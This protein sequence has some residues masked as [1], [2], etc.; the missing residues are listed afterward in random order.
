M[1][2]DLPFLGR[3][4]S[5]P[6]LGTHVT[7]V[8]VTQIWSE[9]RLPARSQRILVETLALW[10]PAEVGDPSIDLHEG[11]PLPLVGIPPILPNVGT[12]VLV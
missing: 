12:E 6:V 3:F 10:T 2:L 9:S 1:A 11:S 7:D 5:G 4:E 8:L